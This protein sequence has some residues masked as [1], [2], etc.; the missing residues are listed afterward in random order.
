MRKIFIILFLIITFSGCIFEK[1]IWVY[2]SFEYSNSEGGWFSGYIESSE[3]KLIKDVII[4]IDSGYSF[5]YVDTLRKFL[6]DYVYPDNQFNVSFEAK[7]YKTV[8]C[9]V[10]IPKGI[11][12]EQFDGVL[13]LSDENGDT[14]SWTFLGEEPDAYRVLIY[15]GFEKIYDRYLNT[16]SI[17]IYPDIFTFAGDYTFYL[18]SLNYS[19]LNNAANGSIV[20]GVY[21]IERNYTITNK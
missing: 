2:V 7:G 1:K 16:N 3:G 10:K 13:S 6:N 9:S 5:I 4:T 21:R 15:K 14:I 17:I 8:Y 11:N 12:L 20:A 19:E 18:L